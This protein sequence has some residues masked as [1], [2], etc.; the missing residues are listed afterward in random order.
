MAR[1][2]K[3]HGVDYRYIRSRTK[4]YGYCHPPNQDKKK[5][6]IGISNKIKGKKE[7][8]INIHEFLHACGWSTMSEEWVLQTSKD[9][10]EALWEL[11]YRKD[12]S[13]KTPEEGSN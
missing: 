10:T 11:G 12:E 2:F 4:D 3:F 6:I 13:K 5:R 9:I 1:R 7:L 8:E